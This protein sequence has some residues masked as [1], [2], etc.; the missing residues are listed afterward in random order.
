MTVFATKN[1]LTDTLGKKVETTNEVRKI[2]K[3]LAIF[4]SWPFG[5]LDISVLASE[6]ASASTLRLIYF[7]LNIFFPDSKVEV[8]WKD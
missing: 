4:D 6:L 5:N 2:W 1:L 3:V 8:S 7:L